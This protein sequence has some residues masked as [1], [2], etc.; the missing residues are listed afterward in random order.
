MTASADDNTV[1][2]EACGPLAGLGI[3]V[4][5]PAAQAEPFCTALTAEG[6]SV[7]RFP[8]LEILAPSDPTNLREVLDRLA[9]FDIA[10]FISPNAV[11]RVLNLALAERTWPA[12]TKIA[13][14]GN[15]TAQELKGFGRPADILP[16]RRFDSEALLAQEAM[17]DVAGKRVVIFRGDGGRELLGDTLK[18][19]GA[20]VTFAEAYRRG[21]PEGDTGELMYAF[22]RGQIGV[23][24]ITSGEGLRNLYEMVGKL[25]RMWLRKT[26]LVVGS[27]RIAEIAQE[28][29]FKAAVETAED[30]TDAAMLAAVHQLAERLRADGA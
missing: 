18:A 20:E 17:Q 7:I 3:L 2:D 24:T 30:P 10:V 29:G 22:S 28:L 14:I 9:D 8:V 16:P 1:V 4:T 5:R 15:R 12:S 21:R 27:E 13:A 11:Q 19:R 6:A 26:P 25:G 23:I